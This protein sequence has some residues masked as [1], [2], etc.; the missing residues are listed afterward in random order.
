MSPDD[1]NQFHN[2][3]AANY[4]YA[5]PGKPAWDSF[6]HRDN[7]TL[8][9][10]MAAMHYHLQNRERPGEKLM[11]ADFARAYFRLAKMAAAGVQRLDGCDRCEQTGYL[12]HVYAT[13]E[14]A[15]TL[16]GFFRVKRELLTVQSERPCSFKHYS[17]R[18]V[19][20]PGCEF[21]RAEL[22]RLIARG[23]FPNSDAEVAMLQECGLAPSVANAWLLY[24]SGHRSKL[25]FRKAKVAE[26]KRST[27]PLG[28]VTGRV[29]K[30]DLNWLEGQ[31]QAKPA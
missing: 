6:L 20:C 3:Y 25:V 29:S 1:A 15:T 23:D 17:L 31:Q 4:G 22:A 11:L 19:P 2:H 26:P 30:N 9:L 28:L 27:E 12:H 18:G 21:G 16:D 14:E 8:S 5:A 10:A 13:N 24:L 7:I